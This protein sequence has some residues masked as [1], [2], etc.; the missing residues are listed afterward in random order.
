MTSPRM[1]AAVLVCSVLAG[2]L[3]GCGGGGGLTKENYDKVT[4]GMSPDEVKGI[5]GEPTEKQSVS[6]ALGGLTGDVSQWVYKEGDDKVIT[7]QFKDGKVVS[8][9]AT[10][11]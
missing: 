5:L 9:V 4:N 7:I 3:A 8:K 6:G 1:I 11:L 10:G 2:V